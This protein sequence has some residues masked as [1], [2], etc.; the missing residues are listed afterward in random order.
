MAG[1]NQLEVTQPFRT[2][3]FVSRCR[4]FVRD[5]IEIKNPD[6]SVAQPIRVRPIRNDPGR[7]ESQS[8]RTKI[9]GNKNEPDS[10][11]ANHVEPARRV[12][13]V[14]QAENHDHGRSRAARLVQIHDST[15]VYS[16]SAKI[17]GSKAAFCI[18]I[19]LFKKL[20]SGNWRATITGIFM[21]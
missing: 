2:P 7:F 14:R 13:A 3:G 10:P 16:R 8:N 17:L 20:G 18:N 5:G 6:I 1:M 21:D 11:A 12:R 19:K 15:V 9:D 4:L